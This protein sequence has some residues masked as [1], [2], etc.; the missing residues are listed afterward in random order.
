MHDWHRFVHEKTG[1]YVSPEESIPEVLKAL[2]SLKL[3][4][5]KLKAIVHCIERHEDYNFTATGNKAET[6]EAKIVQ[7]A[8]NL[9]ASGAIGIAR[10]FM[11]GGFHNFP[12]WIP[13]QNTDYV[14]RG[15]HTNDSSEIAH[16]LVKVLKL[17]DNMNTESARKIAKERH[18]FVEQFIKQFFKEWGN[19]K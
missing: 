1:R 2:E 17:K 5:G 18:E 4:E 9:D 16:L 11:F 7:D 6:L 10:A 12:M 19:V 8:D 14:F 13:E 15:E 3:P